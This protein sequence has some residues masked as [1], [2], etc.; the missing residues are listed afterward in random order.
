M[1]RAENNSLKIKFL[2]RISGT[3][4]SGRSLTPALGCPG[5]ELDETHLF[6]CFKQSANK[7]LPLPL[8]RG[9]CET[10]FKNGRPRPREPFIS[11][12][13]CAQRESETMGYGVNPEIVKQ[14]MAGMSRF[15]SGRPGIRKTL[16]K[17]T[18][19]LLVVPQMMAASVVSASFKP[20]RICT[21]RFDGATG[22]GATGL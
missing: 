14:A 17:K 15:R 18:S 22:V 3:H 6:C 2:G 1:T 4:A 16:G 5:Q 20:T 19:A 12:V 10:K 13:F 9:V 7:A 21:A 11:R 8:G